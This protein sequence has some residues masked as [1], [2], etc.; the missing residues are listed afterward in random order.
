[1]TPL[2]TELAWALSAFGVFAVIGWFVKNLY[3]FSAYSMY[4]SVATMRES[5][6]PKLWADGVEASVADFV[7]YAGF[8]PEQMMPAH[9]RCTLSWIVHEAKRHVAEHRGD[10]GEVCVEWGFV[11]VLI[12]DDGSVRSERRVV[13]TGTA[14]RR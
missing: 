6:V 14:R 5:N 3:P 1:M 8:E 11:N 7:D 10:G 4:A 12:E 13:C 9:T 2:L